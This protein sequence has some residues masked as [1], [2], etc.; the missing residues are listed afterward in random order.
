LAVGGYTEAF[1]SG[2]SGIGR[3]VNYVVVQAKSIT[4]KN[5]LNYD[6]I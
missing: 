1:G 4:I 3:H 6:I 5:K 2:K